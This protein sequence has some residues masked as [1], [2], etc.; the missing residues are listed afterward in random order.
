MNILRRSVAGFRAASVSLL[1]AV[2]A[3]FQAAPDLRAQAPEILFATHPANRT[4]NGINGG[5]TIVDGFACV[6]DAAGNTYVAGRFLGT[7][8]FGTNSYTCV[9][10]YGWDDAYLAKYDPNG[11]VIWSRAFG[12][13]H[14]EYGRAL[15]LDGAGG[16]YFAGYTTGAA[17]VMSTNTLV[18]NTVYGSQNDATL[19]V[20]RFDG[21]GN[22]L[23]VQRAGTWQETQF[24]GITNASVW[25]NSLAVDAGGNLVV[26]GRFTGNPMFGGVLHPSQFS[27]I[28]YTNGVVL[29]N[30][31]QTGTKTEDLFLAKFSSVG[32]LLWA[33]NHGSTNVEF[34]SSVALDSLGNIYAAGAFN[35]FTTLGASNF[36]NSGYA[37]FLTKFD[38]NGVP[39][40]SSN[41]SEPT[42]N[43]AGRAWGVTVDSSNRATVVFQTPT[44]TFRLGTNAFTND[45]Q[46]PTFSGVTASGIAQFETN[47]AV[48]W[49]RRLPLNV[50]GSANSMDLT[51]I[52]DAGNN[53]YVRSTAAIWTNQFA[54]G[55]GGL[56]I[57]K[58]T[59]D[60]A[61]VWTNFTASGAIG[62]V[63]DVANDLRGLPAISLDG[64]GRISVVASITGDA[65]ATGFIGWTNISKAFTNGFGYNLLLLRMESNYVAVAPQFVEQPTNYVFQPP[66]GITNS[67]L[68]RAWPAPVYRWYM[69]SNGTTV[70]ITNSVT[71]STFANTFA[72]WPTTITN[73]TEYYCVA[74][75][76]LQQTTSTVFT[77][78]AK[79]GLYPLTNFSSTVLLG[80]ATT[81]SIN[82]T[83]TSAFSYQWRMNGTNLPGATSQSLL[84][85]YPTTNSGTN[86]YDVVVCNSFG[87]LTST[88]PVSV[89]VKPF[90]SVDTTF[91]VG[92]AGLGVVVEPGRTVLSA[93]NQLIRY[94][95]NGVVVTNG[96][97][98]PGQ[99]SFFYPANIGGG[100]PA[101]AV[102]RD[103]DG[104]IVVGG[105]FTRFNTN[106][107][108]GPALNRMVRFN[109]D[110]TID[111]NFN[112][113]TGPA[114]SQT[115]S[116]DNTFSPLVRTIVRQTD[117]KYLVGGLFNTFN[118]V[119]RTNIVRLNEDGSLD[120][121][122]Q[123]PTFTQSTSPGA[124]AGVRAVALRPGGG[125]V[126]AHEYRTVGGQNL[127][128]VVGLNANGSMDT[129]Y[130]SNLPKDNSSFWG[131][132]GFPTGRALA[133]QTDGKVLLAG[134][135]QMHVATNGYGLIRLNTDGT[136]D[137]TF[138]VTNIYTGALNAVAVQADGKVL[139]AGDNQPT[140][141]LNS[142]GGTD[143]SFVGDSIFNN[144]QIEGI[145]IDS[146]KI[147]VIGALGLYR[148]YG[149]LPTTVV[150][151]PSFSAGT[152]V[153]LPNGQFGFTTCGLPGQTL[154]IQA[155]TNLVNWDS[156]S[157][158]V[159]VSGC[160]DLLDTQAPQIPNR[161][162]RVLVQP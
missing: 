48:R 119:A 158:N 52:R 132:N 13:T 124:L 104:R 126:L 74:S 34:A 67:A 112:A 116:L 105:H 71:Q 111:T 72:V 139:V 102:S 12:S 114:T 122:F 16:V 123:G 136:R 15:A 131:A 9:G 35:K 19:F 129:N 130:N 76:V 148:L 40:W 6:S 103:P 95:T 143:A 45:V 110:A 53:L 66:Q 115:A 31:L 88:P 41:L 65:T 77:A 61:P 128:C 109:A 106:G 154:V 50:N 64:T 85:N 46:S 120:G 22:A 58:L 38:A 100:G 152:A 3:V 44:L 94:T 144:S 101:T 151:Q 159:V 155:S 138:P 4:V 153:K 26:A 157:T 146:D 60:G 113:G 7:T 121:S 21:N 87:C 86:R 96:F 147:Y 127:L 51:V 161:Y 91:V 33:T 23:W 28:T 32:N 27:K 108:T 118:G 2:S 79:L 29:V 83:G 156:I 54:L 43:N 73:V 57:Y 133:V 70:R 98:S 93:G 59:P 5:E 134:Q 14:R 11:N 55:A 42:N 8:W 141:R 78:Q 125:I 68:A 24:S 160:V 49:M 137:L 25:P 62:F 63:D 17:L 92:Q 30:K 142:V 37:P 10:G 162:Y 84:V 117:G 69:R 75:N 107:S 56:T 150:P 140:R 149:T 20:T 1:L 36:T 99:V 90:G 80:G 18:T 47:G 81:F 145:A 89:T 135:F 97:Y 82:A 39:V